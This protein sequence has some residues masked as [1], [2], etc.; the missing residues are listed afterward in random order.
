MS[1]TQSLRGVLSELDRAGLDVT[2]ATLHV[3]HA[4]S[5]DEFVRVARL[6]PATTVTYGDNSLWATRRGPV[7]VAVFAAAWWDDV[8]PSQRE[9]VVQELRDE[10]LAVHVGGAA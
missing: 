3:D 6:L 7:V 1:N 8:P 5:R 9:T 4:E 10:I 2:S